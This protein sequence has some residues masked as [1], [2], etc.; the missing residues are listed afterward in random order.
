MTTHR[1]MACGTGVEVNV[2]KELGVV[3]VKPCE[4]CLS[5]AE[6]ESYEQGLETGREEGSQK[7][8]E[9]FEAGLRTAN[10]KEEREEEKEDVGP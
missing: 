1:C 3:E 9:G 6:E 2:I 10:T 5:V 8:G 7:Y 4:V